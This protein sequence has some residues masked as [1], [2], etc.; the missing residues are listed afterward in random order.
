[1]PIH[2][3]WQQCNKIRSYL[4]Q[5]FAR[6]FHLLRTV[7]GAAAKRRQRDT[8]AMQQTVTKGDTFAWGLRASSFNLFWG[9][10]CLKERRENETCRHTIFI[11]AS[12]CTA[13]QRQI[14]ERETGR[15]GE[16]GRGIS[17]IPSSKEKN[18][19]W[20]TLVG[21]AKEW[22]NTKKKKKKKQTNKQNW[23]EKKGTHVSC[24]P[25]QS[26]RHL[27]CLKVCL[28]KSC[29]DTLDAAAVGDNRQ[30][31]VERMQQLPRPELQLPQLLPLWQAASISC[32]HFAL[33]TNEI[34]R[35]FS[36][37]SNHEN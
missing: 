24:L 12:I 36:S 25:G 7:K 26:L 17:R 33:F 29:S 34:R 13:S 15:E 18:F 28:M 27:R 2:W 23:I 10:Q 30:T 4:E 3:V 1:M 22:R 20:V 31:M 37:Q 14:V 9:T 21:Q 16:W 11:S 5:F 8:N 19:F 35:K 32:C 6:F